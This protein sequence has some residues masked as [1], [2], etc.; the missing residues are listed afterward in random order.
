M[1]VI[2]KAGFQL[3]TCILSYAKEQTNSSSNERRSGISSTEFFFNKKM[4]YYGTDTY[5]ISDYCKG[6][7]YITKGAVFCECVCV[8]YSRCKFMYMSRKQS[9][10]RP[11]KILVSEIDIFGAS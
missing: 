1:F 2:S 8:F 11:R 10:S 3:Q 7:P 4:P 9:Y 5:Q 6:N